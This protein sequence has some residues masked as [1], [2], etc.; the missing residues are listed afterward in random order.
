[1]IPE[2][3]RKNTIEE[4]EVD[5]FLDPSR[6]TDLYRMIVH[7]ALIKASEETLCPN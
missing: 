3:M 1:M 6:E 5:F 4:A 2:K 7:E